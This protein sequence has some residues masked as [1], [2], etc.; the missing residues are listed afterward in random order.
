MQQQESRQDRREETGKNCR[1]LPSGV[2]WTGLLTGHMR[3]IESSREDRLFDD[4]LATA[5]VDF[6]RGIIRTDPDAALPTGPERDSG[7]LTETWYMLATYLGVRTRF[8]DERILAAIA[9]GI[10]QVVIVAAGLDSRA[11]RLDLPA[12]VTV[13]E[14]DTEPVLQFKEVV[15]DSAQLKLK[16]GRRP[17]AADLRGPWAEKLAEMGFDSLRPTMWLVEGL[18]MYLT[19][20]ACDRLLYGIT[21]LSAGGSRLA[22]EYFES[23]PRREDLST[24]DDVESAVVERFLSLFQEGPSVPPHPWLDVHG[25]DIE[26]TTLADEIASHGRDIPLMFQKG[27]PHEIVLWLAHGKLR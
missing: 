4:A 20:E 13:Y 22:L 18:L 8:Y 7:N 15:M 16:S 23:T 25:W 21:S 5:T 10:R 2:G 1:S 6:V 11:V 19:P 3:A 12:D 14:I 9:A 26:I 24:V 17:V 27:R